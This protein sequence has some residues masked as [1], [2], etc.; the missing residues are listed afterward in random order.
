[1]L[2]AQQRFAQQGTFFEEYFSHQGSLR[3]GTVTRVIS[4]SRGG[5]CI[6][7]YNS[8]DPAKYFRR[9]YIR[10]YNVQYMRPTRDK[11]S[12]NI[13]LLRLSEQSLELASVYVQKVLI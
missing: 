4:F 1:M 13:K 2:A 10:F 12:H 8:A 11:E 7:E 9:T 6:L 5:V 3:I